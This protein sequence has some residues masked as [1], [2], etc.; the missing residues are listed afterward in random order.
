[1]DLCSIETINLSINRKVGNKE[2]LWNRNS[3]I[4]YFCI[5]FQMG[6]YKITNYNNHNFP[7]KLLFKF[8][9]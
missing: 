2:K 5:L 6:D 3:K 7:N 1:M 8:I 9:H 4:K